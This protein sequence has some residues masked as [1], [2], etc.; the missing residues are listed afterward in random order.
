[1]PQNFFPKLSVLW[2]RPIRVT[3]LP[4]NVSCFLPPLPL[5]SCGFNESSLNTPQL[6]TLTCLWGCPTPVDPGP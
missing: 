4:R 6:Q 3:S 2:L 5:P 1:M